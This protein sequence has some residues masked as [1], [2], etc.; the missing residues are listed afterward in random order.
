MSLASMFQAGSNAK[1]RKDSF[2]AQ[3]ANIELD[4]EDSDSDDEK[5]N[6]KKLL[7]YQTYNAGNT[8]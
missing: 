1:K 5:L 8:E 2:E 6:K 4:G 7:A 3:M